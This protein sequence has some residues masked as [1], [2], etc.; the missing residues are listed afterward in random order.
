VW[1]ICQPLDPG[2]TTGESVGG[3]WNLLPAMSAALGHYDPYD[4]HSPGD[5]LRKGYAHEENRLQ[6]RLIWHAGYFWL[7]AEAARGDTP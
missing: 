4:S 1:L 7:A 5:P 3:I 6:P 2:T